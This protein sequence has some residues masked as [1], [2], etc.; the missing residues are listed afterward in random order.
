M[1]PKPVL[2]DTDTGVD[3]ALAIILALKS[4]EI[5]LK[6][7]TTVAGNVEVNLCTLNVERIINRL[8]PG[9]MP[10]IGEGAATPLER[11]L[12]TAAEVHGDD[13]LGNTGDK[14]P[15][16]TRLPRVPDA[17]ELILECCE[18]YGSELTIVAVGPLTN[19]AL[20]WQRAP[21]RFSRVGHIVSMGGAFRVPGNTGPVAEFNYY[22]DPEAAHII[23]NSDLP[24]TVVPLD[25]TE[26]LV[27]M[28]DDLNRMADQNPTDLNRF[29]LDFT[30]HYMLFHLAQ[31]KF[32]G[33]YLHDPTAVVMAF[34]P[35]LFQT[36]RVHVDIEMSG[37][38]TRGQSVADFRLTP[39]PNEVAVN[40]A[41]DIDQDSFFRLFFERIT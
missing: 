20:A 14:W 26:Q 35:D 9:T 11:N 19:L 6:A 13:G 31:L 24:I 34:M 5:E 29:I 27:L 40:V 25:L 37:T 2:L 8:A 7:I 21:D 16:T 23:L 36:Q 33:G 12:M 41:T 38:F 17:V 32:Y 18:T 39:R 30:D 1:K 10:R 28:R 4:P 3:D 22:V 15:V